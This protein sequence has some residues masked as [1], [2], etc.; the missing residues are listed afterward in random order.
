MTTRSTKSAN[1]LNVLSASLRLGLTS[2]GGPVAHLGYF[3]E[4][5][6]ERRRGSTIAP[7][8]TSWRCASSCPGRR[9]VRSASR[10]GCRA[11]ATPA[12]SRPGS[13]SRCRRRSRWCCS[14]TASARW[15]RRRRRLAAW[16]QGR[17]RRGGGAGRARHDAHAGARPRARHHGGGRRAIVLAFPTAWGQVG[18]ILLGG[19]RGLCLLPDRRRGAR[20]LPLSGQPPRRRLP[21]CRSSLRCWSDCRCWPRAPEPGAKLFDAFYRAGSLVFGGGHVVLPLLQA[22]SCRRAG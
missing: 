10:S 12:R 6:V 8:P 4:E 5:F 11:P 17:R 2:F 16:A 21:R 13:A 20:C 9:A 22:R 1:W 15:R 7:T 18:A 3:R 19:C 14:P